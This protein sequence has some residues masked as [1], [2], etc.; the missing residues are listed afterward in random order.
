MQK[1]IDYILVTL[2][3]KDEKGLCDTTTKAVMENID[4][5]YQPF[6]TPFVF[7]DFPFQVMVK[8]EGKAS[9]KHQPPAGLPVGETPKTTI[10]IRPGGHILDTGAK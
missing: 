9:S 2:T 3:R 10:H 5:G 4:K 8:Y 1:I 7:G 6:G